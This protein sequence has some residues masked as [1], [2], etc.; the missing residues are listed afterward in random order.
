MAH[1]T[2]SSC[3]NAGQGEPQD[4]SVHQERCSTDSCTTIHL[5]VLVKPLFQIHRLRLPFVGE[6]GVEDL[7]KLAVIQSLKHILEEPHLSVRNGAVRDHQPGQGVHNPLPLSAFGGRE[8]RGGFLCHFIREGSRSCK[9]QC[10][11]FFA[12]RRECGKNAC[13]AAGRCAIMRL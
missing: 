11:E 9:R 7:L 4:V 5:L 2:G 1:G 13:K 10:C 12:S 3:T 8:V 6:P